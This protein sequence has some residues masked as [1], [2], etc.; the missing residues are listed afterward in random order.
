M[1]GSACP[2]RGHLRRVGLVGSPGAGKT[3]LA[4]HLW[5]AWR[6]TDKRCAVLHGDHIG[7][8]NLPIVMRALPSYIIEHRLLLD[9]VLEN[10]V[11]ALDLML[12]LFSTESECVSRTSRLGKPRYP[13][14]VGYDADLRCQIAKAH[15]RGIP[16]A[17]LATDPQALGI[18]L[19]VR[20]A[21]GED[22][23]SLELCGALKVSPPRGAW[24]G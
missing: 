17:F 23:R 8:A 6:E 22:P 16:M 20:G 12:V 4:R 21:F 11:D 2:P 10:G 15:E 13:H 14:Y 9:I 19:D 7:P 3:T 5:R 24:Y 1:N 18:V